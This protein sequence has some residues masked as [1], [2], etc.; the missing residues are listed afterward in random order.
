MPGSGT[1]AF[2]DPDHYE[3]NL[4]Q[5]QLELVIASRGFFRARFTR[6]ERH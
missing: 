5:A 6:A 1:R 4:R 3:A 2:L